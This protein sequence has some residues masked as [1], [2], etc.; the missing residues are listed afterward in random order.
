MNPT[1]HIVR[2]R[3]KQTALE[4]ANNKDGEFYRAQGFTRMGNSFYEKIE[5][6]A[7][8]EIKRQI[9]MHPSK[10]KTLL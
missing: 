1:P 3:V 6:A 10:G 7:V 2:S 9:R 4:L 5:V 8:N